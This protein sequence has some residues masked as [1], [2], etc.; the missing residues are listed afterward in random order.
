ME[1]KFIAVKNFSVPDSG[2]NIRIIPQD[3]IITLEPAEKNG[4]LLTKMTV[5]IP[6]SIYVYSFDISSAIIN[7][8]LP[9]CVKD[10]NGKSKSPEELKAMEHKEP[11]SEGSDKFSAN[12]HAQIKI[13]KTEDEV[14]RF[15]ADRPD[16][17]II[18][19]TPLTMGTGYYADIFFQIVYRA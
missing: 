16:I 18:S 5:N 19:I 2:G 11:K 10:Y 7:P 13:C 3:A 15:L 6:D 8:F 12:R 9:F 17:D 4:G 1:R 14:N